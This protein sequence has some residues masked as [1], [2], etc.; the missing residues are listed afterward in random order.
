MLP[1]GL[2]ATANGLVPTVIAGP[3]LPAVSIGVTEFDPL[4]TTN[5]VFAPAAAQAASAD[6]VGAPLTHGPD[7]AAVAHVARR[8]ADK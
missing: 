2:I 6:F 4:F 3:G 1:S 7:P 8:A 5:A